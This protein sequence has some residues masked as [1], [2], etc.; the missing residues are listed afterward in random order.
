MSQLIKICLVLTCLMLFRPSDVFSSNYDSAVNKAELMIID[1]RIDQALNLYNYAFKTN[2]KPFARDIYNAAVCAI[3]VGKTNLA[4]RYGRTLCSKGVGRPFFEKRAIF[5]PLHKYKQWRPLLEFAQS[6]YNRIQAN[7]I[8]LKNFIDS[9]VE[10]DQLVNSNWRSSAMALDKRQIMDLTYDTIS[11]HLNNLFDSIGF[12]NE[13]RIGVGLEHDTVIAIGLPF[14]VI[15]VHNYQ[16]RE[17]GDTLF[18]KILRKALTEHLIKPDYFA[19]LHDFSGGDRNDYYGSSTCIL[20]IN[21]RYIK[22]KNLFLP[23]PKLK[24]HAG[25]LDCIHL[26]TSKEKFYLS[27]QKRMQILIS[28][29]QFLFMVIL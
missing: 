12:L 4:F 20:S 17:V 24:A 14:D 15:I 13:D 26:M 11:K 23:I 27:F 21:V 28:M 18:N 6:E 7:N 8:G 10:K 16:A 9:L 19:R 2:V 1:N 29:R 25:E 3:K 22:R 5:K